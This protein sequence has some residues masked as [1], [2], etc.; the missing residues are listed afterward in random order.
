MPKILIPKR[1]QFLRIWS[2]GELRRGLE[3]PGLGQWVCQVVKAAEAEA[4]R[5]ESSTQLVQNG[6]RVE[7]W[8]ER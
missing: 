1:E 2:R 7:N 6:S 5:W 3:T 4:S 8:Q